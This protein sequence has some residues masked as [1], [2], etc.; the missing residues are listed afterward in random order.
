M[1]NFCFLRVL[2]VLI[3]DKI[4]NPMDNDVWQLVLQL[5]QIVELLCAPKITAGQVAYLKALIEEYLQ[6]RKEI[7]PDMPLKLKHHYLSH[8]PD[9]TMCFGPLIRLW[10]LRFES[11]HTYFKQFAR[12]L[13]NF[14]NL[15]STLAERHQLLQAYLT[16]D[17][18]LPCCYWKRHR[19]FFT[20]L[21][22]WDTRISCPF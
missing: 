13:Q 4:Q 17:S 1:Q 12:K 14:K 11:K 7:F 15:G 6:C 3:G 18:I 8:Y 21:Q 10:T 9:L 22:W 5:R 20:G 2:P 19:L 16:A